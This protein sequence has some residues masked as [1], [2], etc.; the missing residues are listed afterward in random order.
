MEWKHLNI[1]YRNNHE[2][3]VF[4]Y[5]TSLVPASACFIKYGKKVVDF[6]VSENIDPV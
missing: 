4:E 2:Y 6:K 1:S 5:Y 3:V